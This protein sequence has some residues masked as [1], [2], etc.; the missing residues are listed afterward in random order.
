MGQ[1]TSGVGLISGINTAQLIEQ[2]IALETR[3]KQLVE[4]RNAVL[5]AQQVA[6]QGI[7]AKL[8]A[9]KLTA[10]KIANLSTFN[11]TSASSSNESV[12]TA[13]SSSASVPGT[14]DF[15]VSRLVSTQQAITKGFADP[16]STPIAPQ[17]AD[18]SFEFGDG[19]LDSD[20]SLSRLNGGDG[21][22]R[23]KIRITDRSGS[24]AI[25][26]LGAALTVNDVLD[27][28]NTASNINITASV[29]GDGFKIVDNSGATATN[30]SVANVGS[31][32]T[33]TSLGIAGSVAGST[34]TGQN[35]NTVGVTTRLHNLNDGNGVRYN[36]V[37]NDFNVAL[38][39]GTSFDVNLTTATT[40]GEVIGTI[41]TAA[42]ANATA[43]INDSGTGI[44][45]VDN[46]AGLN[47]TTV[48]ALN[49]SQAAADLGILTS[50][51]N[52]DGTLEGDR[53]IAGLNSKLLKNLRGGQGVSYGFSLGPRE[54][55]T[56]T[57]LS[58]LFNGAG[59]ATSG[60]IA[61]DIRIFSRQTTAT[62]YQINVDALTT[63]EDLI[64]AFDS[65]TGGRVT[66]SIEGNQLRATDNTGGSH[67]LTIYSINSGTVT[68]QL[69]LTVNAAVSTVLGNDTYPPH[70]V[71]QDYGPG[72]ML[73]TNRSGVETEIDFSSA[74]SVQ[75]ILRIVNESGAG[76]TASL[77]T[78]G[79]GITLTDTSGGSGDLI[80]A[81]YSGTLATDLGIAGTH[82]ASKVETGNLQAR[83][84]S[85]ATLLDS[86]RG[87]KGVTRGKFTITDSAG[88][89]ATVDLTQGDEKSI[90]DV[91]KEINSRGLQI[92]A[93]IND[94][95]DGILIEDTGPG[96]VALKI[97]EAGS[98]TARDLGILGEATTPGDDLDGS[99]EKTI[100]LEATDTLDDLVTK[101][102]DAGID[103]K[104]TIVN[105][106]TS[107]T[108]Y[109]LSLLSTVAG[110]AGEFVFDDEGLGFGASTLVK[111]Q[112]AAVFFGSSDPARGVAI[113]S[114][115][116][117]LNAVIPGA[118]I[119]LKGA[120]TTPTRV[121]ISRNDEEIS[122]TI[123]K[124]VTD[125]NG[126]AD[127]LDSLD[128]YDAET[129][130]KGLLLG[131]STIARVR[132]A[133]FSLVNQ[134]VSDVSGQYVTLSQVGVKVGPG[135]RLVFDESKLQTALS[136]DREAV[137]QLFTL[138][139][140]TTDAEGLIK[141]AT[142][143]FGTKLS[144]LIKSLT[145]ST[146]G[147]LKLKDDALTNVI[148]LNKDRITSL[149]ARLEARRQRL[150]F[151]F[152]AMER[153]LA[154]LQSQ[155]TAL[156][157]FQPLQASSSS[158]QSGS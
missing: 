89:S 141:V 73:V 36:D 111:A 127:S 138:K 3:P 41:N 116:N 150:Q 140:T 85:E 65:A 95:G 57:L 51:I 108:P 72:Q 115:T 12:L 149:D 66:L 11:A 45:I 120:S 48:T 68:D 69:G 154:Q 15:V 142:A 70:E 123:N 77:N 71:L 136:N 67:N 6:F 25:I 100:S 32:N 27:Q 147:A 158:S 4:Q 35:I 58:D 83:Y 19:R 55:K 23:G 105:D 54:L 148:E 98:T 131:D 26:D 157:S 106:G 33:A 139:T 96:V 38:R 129:E 60:T 14:Y 126:L 84:V 104:A 135:S 110:K 122:T 125:F 47:T 5:T 130:Q 103:I 17:G 156:S 52:G 46:T 124:F 92:N 9:L 21:V 102:A 155:G 50:D 112:N 7:N 40:L 133:M 144:E 43:S 152:D 20:T 107:G 2:L 1:I 109:R 118:T 128:S 13:S 151:Q 101:I 80:I 87:G 30:L 97:V 114:A 18:L 42:G 143:G 86:L 145:D 39:D 49:N 53:V 8:L 132:S 22:T 90:N 59:M 62:S 113:T 16:N 99:F 64:N 29:D 93:R 91:L 81:D 28:I 134:R 117:T 74:R 10:D 146:N 63:V 34:L 44:K 56:T 153:A 137:K 76:I 31:T 61:N 121:V 24:S 37:L 88:G 79:N 119:N 75:D 78:A 82:T 94:T